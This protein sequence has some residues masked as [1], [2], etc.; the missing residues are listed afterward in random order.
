MGIRGSSYSGIPTMTKLFS[1]L[2]LTVLAWPVAVHADPSPSVNDLIRDLRAAN[3]EQRVTAAAALAERGPGA[4]PAVRALVSALSDAS[5][6][7]QLAALQALKQI[8]RGARE[9]VPAL[10]EILKGDD[11][12]KFGG[13]IGA[14]GAIGAEAQNAAPDLVGFMLGEDQQLSIAACRA[15]IRILP[16]NHQDVPQV[17][18][19]LVQ[20]LKAKDER[21]RDEAVLTLGSA[22]SIAVPRL[23]K[24]VG[25]YAADPESAARAAAALALLGR[26]AEPAV[27]ALMKALQSGRESVVVQAA[28][29]LSSI[30]PA[31]EPAVPQLTKILSGKSRA[32]RI[33][34][35]NALGEIGPGSAAAVGDIAV[36]LADRDENIRRES[37]QALGKIGPESRPAIPALMAALGD[38]CE[39][40]KGLAVWALGRIGGKAVPPLIAL[41]DDDNLQD[42]AIAALGDIGPAARPAV[43]SLVELLRKPGISTERASDIILALSRI[44]PAAEEAATTL[45]QI[46]AD[47]KSD[48][49]PYAAWALGQIGAKDEIPQLIRALF[50]ER[51][52][53]SELS[54]VILISVLTLDPEKELY[55]SLALK[56]VTELLTNESGLVRQAAATAL[57]AV[58]KKAASAV[59]KLAAGLDDPDPEVR[60]A[61]LAALAAIGPEAVEALPA[62]IKLLADPA[63]PVR[64]AASFAIGKIGP[65]AKVTAPVLEQNLQDQDPVLRFASA[66]ALVQVDPQRSNLAS[67][68]V[69]PLRW[70]LKS[71]DSRVRKEAA[72]ALGVLGLEAASSVSDREAAGK[73]DGDNVDKS[74]RDALRNINQPKAG[75]RGFFERVRGNRGG[76]TK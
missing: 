2:M 50:A 7:V 35:L 54:V 21:V 19:V 62:V 48:L 60:S 68:C 15:L 32:I 74:A 28:A 36:A 42:T 22:G 10:I 24:L 29:T 66:W 72:Q 76:V 39:T 8:G 61:F 58:G 53:G 45:L 30:G 52:P 20:A 69:E 27:A 14:L 6:E 3:A 43:H 67:L 70:G 46:L 1:L 63:Y 57:A 55:F 16:P 51:D 4:A 13:A 44:G 12:A 31:A 75:S 33:A 11:S 23:A 47:E 65:A 18:S 41:L 38:D 59:P 17:V 56:G 37:A 9:A 34:A 71:D 26:E 40:V 5:G 25:A 49:R 64:Y 73:G